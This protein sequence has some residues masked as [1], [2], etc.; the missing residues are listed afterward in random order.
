ME[1]NHKKKKS[2]TLH[3]VNWEVAEASVFQRQYLLLLGMMLCVLL[4][5]LLRIWH[6]QVLNGAK[7]RYQSENNRIRLE[8]IPA[9]RGIIFDR[10]GTPLVENRPA[11]HLLLIREDVQ[12]V[13]QT[14][15]ELARLCERAPEEFL[16]ILEANKQ[17]PRFVPLRLLS[18]LDRDSLARIEAQRIHLPG[19]VI[20]LEPKREYRCNGTAAHLIG[21]LSEITETELKNETYLGYYMGEDIGKFGVESAFEK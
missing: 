6:L 11:Y 15:R 7:Y 18:D 1:N 13:D 4:I 12:D 19:V 8:D 21:Y 20:Q 14:L 3:L 10:N 9:P 5:Y 16:A 17:V 2:E